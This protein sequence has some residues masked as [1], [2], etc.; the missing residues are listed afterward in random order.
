ME[1]HN[2]QGVVHPEQ[3][4]E[5]VVPS[6]HLTGAAT[7]RAIAREAEA[8]V[9]LIGD[10][11][12]VTGV[13]H[14]LQKNQHRHVNREGVNV[15]HHEISG[16]KGDRRSGNFAANSDHRTVE[17]F[18]HARK[19][20][21]CCAAGSGGVQTLNPLS[22][23]RLQLDGGI[24]EHVL[25]TTQGT[26]GVVVHIQAEAVC[27]QPDADPVQVADDGVTSFEHPVEH[28]INVLSGV[29]I[30]NHGDGRVSGG[31][32][33]Q[34]TTNPHVVGKETNLSWVVDSHVRIG[35]H[36]VHVLSNDDAHRTADSEVHGQL[37]VPAVGHELEQTVVALR[38]REEEGIALLTLE[39]LLDGVTDTPV[40]AVHVT[41]HDEHHRNRQV[42][43]SDV[44]HPHAS[45]HRIQTTFKGEEIAIGSPVTTEESANT[46]AESGVK[47][48]QEILVEEF[49][50]EGNVRHRSNGF[51]VEH[52]RLAGVDGIHQLGGGQ[53]HMQQVT[54]PGKRSQAEQ[55]GQVVVEHRLNVLEPLELWSCL[56]IVEDACIKHQTGHHQGANGQRHQ[57]RLVGDAPSPPHV[58]QA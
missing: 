47:L 6:R 51:A 8:E 45:R 14:T 50:R 11:T 3:T 46:S 57:L 24:A 36:R 28:V 58:E 26:H 17:H 30:A 21:G 34:E 55:T 31:A 7:T 9:G 22:E 43:M 10:E 49:V 38:C 2:R 12:G 27:T 56:V 48:S 23:N 29:V 42:V 4:E 39:D 33:D 18:T 52:Q 54:S 15:V 37:S 5:H 13:K 25:G 32:N 44:A 19:S 35:R 53:R 20:V 16:A 1:D 41:G 40:G